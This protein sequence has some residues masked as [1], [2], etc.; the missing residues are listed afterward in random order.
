M[1]K[2]R[3]NHEEVSMKD[4][5]VRQLEMTNRVVGFFDA[6]PM[7]FRKG[8]PGADLVE[9]L[10]HEVAELQSLTATQASEFAHSR[11]YSRA[12]GATRES[13]NQAMEHIKRTAEAIAVRIPGMEARF[14]ASRG[15]GDAKLETRARSV[16]ESAK[17]FVQQFV[18]FEMEPKFLSELESKIKAFTQAVADHKASRSAHAATTQLIDG[19]MERALISLAQLDP[20]I[21]NKLG[22][23]TALRLKWENVRRVEKRWIYKTPKETKPETNTSLIPAA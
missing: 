19:A 5:T 20:I 17:P 8:T 7:G 2:Q 14:E 23:N 6:N 12:R 9:Q 10:K 18:D 3:S 16:M 11:A 21:E 22:G 15:V 1:F 4:V 13:L